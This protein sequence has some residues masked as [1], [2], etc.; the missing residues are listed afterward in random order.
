MRGKDNVENLFACT[1]AIASKPAPTSGS[2]VY[3]I[4]FFIGI[5][6]NASPDGEW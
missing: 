6:A 5:H 1:S 3:S 4:R 2:G